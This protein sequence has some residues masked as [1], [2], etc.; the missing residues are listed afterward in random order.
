MSLKCVL[1]SILDLPAEIRI[2]IY[3]CVF[4]SDRYMWMSLSLCTDEGFDPFF[5]ALLRTSSQIRAEARPVFYKETVFAFDSLDDF[6]D[7]VDLSIMSLIR[8]LSFP[9]LL[10]DLSQL[11]DLLPMLR[12]KPCIRGITLVLWID[13][14]RDEFDAYRDALFSQLDSVQKDHPLLLPIMPPTDKRKNVKSP[15]EL[16]TLLLGSKIEVRPYAEK[17][18][19]CYRG[20]DRAWSQD[21]TTATSTQDILYMLMRTA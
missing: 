18:L 20:Q 8:K 11:S 2:R 21:G 7:M 19:S 15:E 3:H 12:T 16:N 6:E 13:L 1:P 9:T 4:S 14:E 17:D 10:W 5:P